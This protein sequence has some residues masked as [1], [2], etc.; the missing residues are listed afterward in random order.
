VK[1][2]VVALVVAALSFPAAAD[3]KRSAQAK[4]QFQKANPCPV[5]LAHRGRCPGYD[6]DH[7]VPLCAGGADSPEN[8]QWLTKSA[9]KEKTRRDVFECRMARRNSLA[10]Q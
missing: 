10:A 3:A 1:L 5:N 9:H 2:L 4:Y 6:I 8:M 7:I